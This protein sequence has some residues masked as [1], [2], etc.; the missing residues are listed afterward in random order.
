MRQVVIAAITEVISVV[1]SMQ[2]HAG[3]AVVAV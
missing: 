3:A 2:V 1:S